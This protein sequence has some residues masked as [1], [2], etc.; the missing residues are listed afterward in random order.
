MLGNWIDLV[1][2]FY[3]LVYFFGGLGK[4]PLS[5]IIDFFCFAAA[6]V[7]AAFFYQYL[8]D[9]LIDNFGIS[10]AYASLAGFFVNFFVFKVVLSLAIY[11]FF[12]KSKI[13]SAIK[14][15]FLNRLLGAIAS[16]AYGGLVVFVIL[17]L[18]FALSLPAPIGE[19][20]YD[21]RAGAFVADDPLKLNG[22]FENIFGG[23]LRDVLK[24][25][26]FLTVEVGSNEIN[27]LDFKAEE[28]ELSEKDEKEMLELINEERQKIGLVKLEADES[29]KEVARDYAF[30]MFENSYVAHRDLKGRMPADRLREAGVE[31][32]FSGEN[33]AL[34]ANV[35]SAHQGLMNSPGH[36]K[37]I[38]FPFFRKVGIGAVD[39][40]EFGVMFVQNFTD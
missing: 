36:R 12:S 29:L 14:K 11:H 28:L 17:S 34:S 27:E 38:L 21:S 1:I 3:L 23:V 40:G 33:I 15:T 10:L 39:S 5:V 6:L 9:F 24:G 8:A 18:T 22:E 2:I 13:F 25:L 16:F 37:N 32:Y 35:S 20:F 4:K 7:L 31:F 26:E 30:Y 19:H